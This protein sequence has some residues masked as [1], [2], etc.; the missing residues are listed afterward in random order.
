[1]KEKLSLTLP[2]QKIATTKDISAEFVGSNKGLETKRVI[3]S[4]MR[5]ELYD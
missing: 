4:T 3:A 1:L 2:V 5:L